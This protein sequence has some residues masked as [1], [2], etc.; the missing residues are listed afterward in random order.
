MFG[1]RVGVGGL[2][3]EGWVGLERR[4]RDRVWWEGGKD[5]DLR[6][7]WGFFFSNSLEGPKPQRQ[8]PIQ[9]VCMGTATSR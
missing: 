7:G 1:G 2:G 3:S 5:W 9:I 8:F 6:Q 4:G